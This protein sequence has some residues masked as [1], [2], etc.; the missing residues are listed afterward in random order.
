M[1]LSGPEMEGPSPRDHDASVADTRR[2]RSR[3]LAP[4]PKG[5]GICQMR[6]AATRAG[7]S[8]MAKSR[9]SGRKMS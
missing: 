5:G 8:G 2:P 6:S 4:K 7:R 3:F 1:A 9:P